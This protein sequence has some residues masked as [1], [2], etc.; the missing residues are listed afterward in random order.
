[1]GSKINEFLLSISVSGGEH[2]GAELAQRTDVIKLFLSY[3]PL[4]IPFHPPPEDKEEKG[5]E[6]KEKKKLKETSTMIDILGEYLDPNAGP[7]QQGDRILRIITKL[8]AEQVNEQLSPFFW[9]LLRESDFHGYSFQLK[10][11]IPIVEKKK[12]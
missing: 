10:V 12:E 4:H 11:L 7:W 6:K 3:F 1:M 2:S 9:K 8:G 5:K